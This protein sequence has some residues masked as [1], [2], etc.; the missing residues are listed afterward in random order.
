[1]EIYKASRQ[2]AERPVDERF[3]SPSDAVMAAREHRDS[4]ATST[5]RYGD[6]RVEARG[7]DIALLGRTDAPAALTHYA[8]GQLAGRVKAPAEYLRQLPPTLAAQNLNHGLKARGAGGDSAHIILV[9]PIAVSGQRSAVSRPSS[10]V[11]GQSSAHRELWAGSALTLPILQIAA[12]DVDGGGGNELV[13][14]EG[15]YATGRHGPATHV[16]VWRW[17][18]FG[19]TLAWRSPPGRFV[20]L[21]LANLGGDGIA[22]ILVR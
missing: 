9:E 4:A 1:M 2:W 10:V 22:K 3:W 13:A 14:L 7:D 5:V 12:G 17:N 6:L 21:V 18:G 11:G 19:F 15:D 16:S 20:A 8:F